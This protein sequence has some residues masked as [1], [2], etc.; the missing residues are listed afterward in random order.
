MGQGTGWIVLAARL[1]IWLSLGFGKDGVAVTICRKA[2]IM[3]HIGDLK[4]VEL[5]LVRQAHCTA[6]HLALFDK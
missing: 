3:G 1:I 5:S 6:D 2:R 4:L